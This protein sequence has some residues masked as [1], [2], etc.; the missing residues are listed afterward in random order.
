MQSL[1]SEKGNAPISVCIFIPLS[2]LTKQIKRH[3]H[4]K[5]AWK[6]LKKTNDCQCNGK[7]KQSCC[8]CL[9]MKT[10][11]KKVNRSGTLEVGNF[12]HH[13]QPV[14]CLLGL[15]GK[16][17][18]TAPPQHSV[19]PSFHSFPTPKKRTAAGFFHHTYWQG[20]SETW[21]LSA[22]DKV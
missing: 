20:E 7:G 22:L 6:S 18:M 4:T 3:V 16:T 1:F 13:S 8:N 11:W 2:S 12:Q 21:Q 9:Q 17:E 19:T 10:G 15:R 5:A 14:T